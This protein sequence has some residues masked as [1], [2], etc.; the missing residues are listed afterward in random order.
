M[1]GERLHERLVGE[2]LGRIFCRNQLLDRLTHAGVGN[3]LAIARLIPRRKERTHFHQPLRR[4]QILAGDRAR[5][6]GR[7]HA[8]FVGDF[9]HRERT[10]MT[11][12]LV[13][14]IR[15][16]RDELVGNRQNRFLTQ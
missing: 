8:Q 1:L 13:E 9:I 7:M 16:M 15:L 11:R 3:F 4:L 14:E 12:A 2:R 5:N 6:G 10:Q